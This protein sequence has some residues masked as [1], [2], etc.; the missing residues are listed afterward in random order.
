MKR[1]L[2]SFARAVR[3]RDKSEADELIE[4]IVQ[5]SL[6]DAVW[7]GYERA[8]NGMSEALD[9]DDGLRLV[10]QIA[11]EK[12]SLKRLEKIREEM[13]ERASQEFRPKDE[14]GYNK[15]W[16]DVLKVM[17]EDAK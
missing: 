1:G 9:S 7:E 14:R 16:S 3:N 15:A 4:K 17:I 8:L 5:G 2:K 6:D 10:N 11:E 13:E 12:F